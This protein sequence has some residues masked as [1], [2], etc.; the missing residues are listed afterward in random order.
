MFGAAASTGAWRTDA[1][2]FLRRCLGAVV[3]PERPQELPELEGYPQ[4]AGRGFSRFGNGK[5]G[6]GRF[7][8]NNW[9]KNGK[10]GHDF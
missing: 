8:R 7:K 5:Q 9:F 3:Q 10:Q 6:D 2:A 1:V 4:E